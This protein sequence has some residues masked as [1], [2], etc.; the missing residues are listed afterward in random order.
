MS[1]IKRRLTNLIQ[2]NYQWQR[3]VER[4]RE[5]VAATAK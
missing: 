4:T 3:E 1:P 2:Q 5:L